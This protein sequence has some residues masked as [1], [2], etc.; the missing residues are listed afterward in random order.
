MHDV[1]SK[2][3][4]I[5]N[6][7]YNVFKY[8]KSTSFVKF[9]NLTSCIHIQIKHVLRCSRSTLVMNLVAKNNWPNFHRC[10][11]QGGEYA[12][13]KLSL[14]ERNVDYSS[15][16]SYSDFQRI[17]KTESLSFTKASFNSFNYSFDDFLIIFEIMKVIV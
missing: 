9:E 3:L 5:L 11:R 16:V 10:L 15:T 8:K 1:C 7:L 6:V 13:D 12:V 14:L 4:T 2:Y 17:T